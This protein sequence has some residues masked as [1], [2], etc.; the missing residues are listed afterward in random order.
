MET[1]ENMRAQLTEKKQKRE[2]RAQLIYEKLERLKL[3]RE[4]QEGK[5]KIHEEI[6]LS[7]KKKTDIHDEE[8]KERISKETTDVLRTLSV[9]DI[10]QHWSWNRTAQILQRLALV[11][12]S[13]E[14]EN[15]NAYDLALVLSKAKT[16][17]EGR[18]FAL[19][20]CSV[21]SKNHIHELKKILFEFEIER[22]RNEPTTF[23]RGESV[24]VSFLRLEVFFDDDNERFY[25]D[26]ICEF[27]SG[28]WDDAKK[29]IQTPGTANTY[30]QEIS[31]LLLKFKEFYPKLLS[32]SYSGPFVK[33]NC[34]RIYSATQNLSK[35]GGYFFLR[36]LQTNMSRYVQE[37]LALNKDGDLTQGEVDGFIAN[38][39]GQPFLTLSNNIGM[40]KKNVVSS[41]AKGKKQD[42]E[43]Q[44]PSK[45]LAGQILEKEL[46][47]EK[48]QKF[49]EKLRKKQK[50]SKEAS[51]S[52]KPFYGNTK[53]LDVL[54]DQTKISQDISDFF[55][56][57]D[58]DI[59]KLEKERQAKKINKPDHTEALFTFI[60]NQNW[61]SI[62]SFFQFY[63]TAYAAGF[64]GAYLDGLDLKRVNE[65]GYTPLALGL[66]K[67]LP[68]KALD[69]LF[70]PFCDALLDHVDVDVKKQLLQS[71]YDRQSD[72]R[73]K[74]NGQTLLHVA[75]TANIGDEEDNL[76]KIDWVLGKEI[77]EINCKDDRDETSL[78]CAIKE[79][80]F[81]VAKGL[82]E[83]GAKLDEMCHGETA[84]HLL[85]TLDEPSDVTRVRKAHLID[86][87]L[88][89][90]QKI[91][92][93][94]DGQGNTALHRALQKEKKE[95]ALLL[96]EKG[97]ALDIKNLDGI[98]P[99]ILAG[100]LFAEDKKSDGERK[101]SQLKEEMEKQPLKKKK[102]GRIRK[103]TESSGSG[104]FDRK[105]GENKKG[106]TDG[107]VNVPLDDD[108]KEKP[109]KTNLKKQ[110][111]FL[112]NFRR[113]RS[114][115]GGKQ[116]DGN[117]D[118]KPA[119]PDFW[120]STGLGKQ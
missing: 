68:P 79:K 48:I 72:F 44:A 30:T 61:Q 7:G 116:K 81:V 90:D 87:F 64:H 109:K 85:V 1:K 10:F 78:Y 8:S 99:V 5:K 17:K 36:F 113:H 118:K 20:V 15:F 29:I 35:V 106:E 52:E 25:R 95:I 2:R 80:K 16:Q 104:F 47:Q 39:F 103:G 46:K 28:I 108:E 94:K 9:A 6:D 59:E 63:A 41:I 96:K 102:S 120:A 73:Q 38:A 37:R 4:F 76:E 111:S 13:S 75:A 23:M 65:E 105:G 92:D 84:F 69:I 24:L 98:T 12:F 110:S 114:G 71:Q 45:F 53:A 21:L 22:T 74:I 43:N 93:A 42:E 51:V 88:T 18:L 3:V 54:G 67:N 119:A 86:V 91:L 83:R 11:A 33:E 77:L 50:V 57:V 56:D 31:Q 60:K 117:G 32:S 49:L 58:R 26:V 89:A 55:E 14:N 62:F 40:A 19:A 27:L 100:D 34:F 107:F 101:L 82:V 112:G 97:A 115:S 66:V 70:N